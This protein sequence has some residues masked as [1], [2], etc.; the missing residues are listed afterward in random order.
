MCLYPQN[1]DEI[2]FLLRPRRWYSLSMNLTW[3][4]ITS[5][6]LHDIECSF[7]LMHY[8]INGFSILFQKSNRWTCPYSCWRR[9]TNSIWQIFNRGTSKKSGTLSRSLHTSFSWYQQ[10]QSRSIR[11]WACIWSYLIILILSHME[12]IFGEWVRHSITIIPGFFW[13]FHIAFIL[14]F[15]TSSPPYEEN[16][17]RYWSLKLYIQ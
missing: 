10:P 6:Q 7:Q 13:I 11:C 3:R 17:V 15:F 2:S 8:L 4:D 12:T 14:S 5:G 9:K 1:S 16:S